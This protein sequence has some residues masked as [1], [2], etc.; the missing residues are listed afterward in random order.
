MDDADRDHDHEHAGGLLGGLNRA[1]GGGTAF[2]IHLSTASQG[3]AA[4]CADFLGKVVP[5]ELE[6]GESIVTH[7]HAFLCAESS[8]L[9]L[10][11]PSGGR[12]G[13]WRRVRAAETHRT[14]HGLRRDGRRRD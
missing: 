2:L 8:V 13:R 7:K 5:L 9:D 4:F 10:H 3:R 6:A 1:F 12:A 14:G 11:A